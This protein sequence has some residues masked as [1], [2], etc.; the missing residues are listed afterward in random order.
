MVNAGK[1]DQGELMIFHT[2]SV[3]RVELRDKAGQV[4]PEDRKKYRRVSVAFVMSS[5]RVNQRPPDTIT[6]DK[7]NRLRT[8]MR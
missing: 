1:N 3:E 2:E 6:Q 8:L 4:I 7:L 5:G